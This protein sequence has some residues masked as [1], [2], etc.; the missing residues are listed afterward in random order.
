MR[1]LLDVTHPADVHFF[2]R[3]LANWRR[4]GHEVDVA[5]RDKDVAHSLLDGLGIP[6]VPVG[7]AGSGV[8][9]LARELLARQARL[10]CLMKT[11]RPDVVAAFGGTFVVH[12]ARRLGVR[13]VVFTDTENARVSNA[14][15]LPFAS[16][17]CTP[18]CYPRPV[19]APQLRYRGYKE[20]SYLHPRYFTP[21]PAALPAA[22]LR[23]GEP[24]VFMRLVS[25]RSGHDFFDHG[26]TD[27]RAAVQ[28]LQR[29]ARVVLSVEGT[30]PADLE[31][32][33]FRGP[34]EQVH[35]V[36]AGARLYLGESP[37]MAAEAA[38][39]GTPAVVV[40]TSRRSYID[41]LAERYGLV[42]HFDHPAR[43]QAQ[44]LEHAEALL[45][46]DDTAARGQERRARMLAEQEDVAEF[47][48]DVV[49]GRRGA[50]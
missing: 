48:T 35:H 27:V 19:R 38:M 26:L 47:V 24:F 43:G 14:I 15:T 50:A 23:A 5:A 46:R 13:S 44:A 16:L 40:S 4:A 33:R 7:R 17:V 21:D 2:A 34:V 39:L 11:R 32:L 20:L 42:T 28:R 18:R 41:E 36:L 37:T 49:V 29:H 25:W 8:L 22:G 45:A 3:P 1:I 30:L 9:G 10:L 31:A 12:P 6:F